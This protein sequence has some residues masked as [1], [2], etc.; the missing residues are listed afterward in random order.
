[1][2][3]QE[4]VQRQ[5]E[6]FFESFSRQHHTWLTSLRVQQPTGGL[7]V[8]VIE[9]PLEDV[10]LALQEDNRSVVIQIGDPVQHLVSESLQDPVSV[11]LRETEQGAHEA[12][13]ISTAAGIRATLE[14]RS[15][16][17]PQMLNGVASA[18]AEE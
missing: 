12:V 16:V 11:K 7:S 2:P 5:W 4:I 3:I 1:M 8:E 17:L 18:E 13:E 14:F 6:E 10:R 15:A 9:Q